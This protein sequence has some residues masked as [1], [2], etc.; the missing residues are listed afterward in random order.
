M[1]KRNTVIGMVTDTAYY[2]RSTADAAFVKARGI[3]LST[4]VTNG[5]TIWAATETLFPVNTVV[6]MYGAKSGLQTGK[7]VSNNYSFEYQNSCMKQCKADYFTQ[8]GDKSKSFKKDAREGEEYH[9]ELPL[10]FAVR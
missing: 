9:I 8:D 4:R 2:W 5:G 3:A 1:I 7:I 6:S 10:S